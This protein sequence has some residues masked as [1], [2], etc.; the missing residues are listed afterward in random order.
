MKHMK[1]AVATVKV[2]LVHSL[3]CS[4]HRIAWTKQAG[5]FCGDQL[6]GLGLEGKIHIGTGDVFVC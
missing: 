6:P 2:S 4:E 3:G 5:P 1:T